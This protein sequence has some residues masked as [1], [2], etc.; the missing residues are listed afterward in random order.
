MKKQLDIFKAGKRTPTQG[1]A[2]DFT[3]SIIDA[4]IAAYDPAL[5]EAPLVIGHPKQNAPAW[6][7]VKSLTKGAD[8]VVVAF[9][10]Q[11]NADFA[12]MVD[13]GA[14]KK[15]SAS[16]YT[17]N[18][19]QNPVP[20]VY[21]LRHVGFLGAQPP[22]VKGLEDGMRD[23]SFSAP[24]E[25]FIEFSDWDQMSIASIFRR[26]REWLISTSGVETAD[27]VIP[28]YEINS[29]QINAALDRDDADI[30]SPSFNEPNGDEMTPEQKARMEQL[31]ADNQKL[32]QANSE[33]TLRV[34]NFEEANAKVTQQAIHTENLNFAE[35]LVTAGKILPAQK[36]ATMALLN[37]LA[38]QDTSLDFGEGD[39]KTSKSPLQ[40]YKD[41]LNATPVLV[42]FNE[43]GGGPSTEDV[44][45]FA[46]PAGM[47]V[48]AAR[49]ALHHKAVAYSQQHGV[50][51]DIAITKV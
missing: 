47:G 13:S 40:I 41:Q 44:V 10:E 21:Y 22:S 9:A 6:G 38:Q 28:D 31:E 5:H 1:G 45:D 14:F 30:S 12:E 49:L 2:I 29:L 34:A 17:P 43:V 36:D 19:P 26:L 50:A 11:V 32:T 4:S 20:G 48:D 35:G 23:V 18:S 3:E 25:D 37:Q 7:W 42:N 24:D 8:N 16:F 46:A 15:K 39:S 33:L 51:Y 27:K